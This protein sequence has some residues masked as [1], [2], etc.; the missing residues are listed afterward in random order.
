[1]DGW[2][3]VNEEE[4]GLLRGGLLCDKTSYKSHDTIHVI[5][6]R[7]RSPHGKDG[8]GEE[9]KSLASVMRLKVIQDKTA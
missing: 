3:K 6:S 1:M 5:V 8:G 9:K 2:R 4:P 7:A